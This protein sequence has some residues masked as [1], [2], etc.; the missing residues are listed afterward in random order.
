[1]GSMALCQTQK[2][3]GRS[4][5][6]AVPSSPCVPGTARSA[7]PAPLHRQTCCCCHLL[8]KMACPSCPS[9]QCPSGPSCFCPSCPSYTHLIMCILSVPNARHRLPCA[10]AG[11]PVLESGIQA[12]CISSLHAQQCADSGL[13]CKVPHTSC[14]QDSTHT[15]HARSHTF[16]HTTSV[17]DGM[18]IGADLSS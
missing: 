16:G 9:C 6:C 7:S 2:D 14:S 12:K 3:S 5:C 8:G 4:S 15:R 1:M 13:T 11:A 17:S 18:C 10:L